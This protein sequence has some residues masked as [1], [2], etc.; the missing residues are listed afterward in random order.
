MRRTS[1]KTILLVAVAAASGTAC[2]GEERPPARAPS[3]VQST[4]ITTSAA[5]TT[6]DS[7][8]VAAGDRRSTNATTM[9]AA[10]PRPAPVSAASAL[11]RVTTARCER[12]A[13]CNNVGT[14]R[15]FADRHA[16]ANE[17][18]HHVV[19]VLSSEDCPSGV[20]ESKLA[21]CVSEIE[22]EPCS[23]NTTSTGGPPSCGRE[24]LC[25]ASPMTDER[26]STER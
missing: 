25:V 23:D 12:H 10:T 13:A 11:M 18:G 15:L 26:L 9:N 7:S 5:L 3:A 22:S 14:N 1:G 21:T 17:I 2:G 6:S 16:C 19:S 24:R 4:T 8:T 20:D